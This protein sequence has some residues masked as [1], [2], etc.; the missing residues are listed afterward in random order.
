MTRKAIAVAMAVMMA[1]MVQKLQR[2]R[3]LVL[4]I[5]TIP[6]AVSDLAVSERFYRTVLSVLGAEP[7]HADAE[8]VEGPGEGS[9]LGIGPHQDGHVGGP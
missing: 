6:L 8:L 9:D 3:D 4:W 2:G 7:S 1:T 5:W